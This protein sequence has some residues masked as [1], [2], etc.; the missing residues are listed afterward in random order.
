MARSIVITSGKGGVGKSTV[1]A[2]L[3]LHLAEKNYRVCMID[4]DVGLN[5]LD[6][7]TNMEDRIVYTITDVIENKCRLKEALVQ[8]NTYPLLYL[9]STGGLNTN[10]SIFNHS[11]NPTI[12]TM[13]T[14][15]TFD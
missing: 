7:V 9:L 13:N 8:D 3:G 11:T 1:T 12:Y 10:L 4:M 5:N 6:I 15:R 2:N 14:S